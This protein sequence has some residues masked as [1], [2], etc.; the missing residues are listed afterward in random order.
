MLAATLDASLSGNFLAGKEVVRG[1]DGV[2]QAGEGVIRA[3]EGHD[4]KCCL[5]LNNFEI[6]KNYQNEP[7]L[8]R[9]YSRNN[10]PKIKRDEYKSIETYWIALYVMVIMG[11]ILIDLGWTYFKRD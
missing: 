9:V 1:G 3:G 6:Q 11:Y 7:K 4:F 2:I 8:N 5:I 10:L